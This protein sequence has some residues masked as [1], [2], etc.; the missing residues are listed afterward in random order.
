M[1]I[2]LGAWL[3]GGVFA[4]ML[5]FCRIG[6]AFM[7]L[8]GFGEVFT[9]ARFRL[10]L[11]LG[12]CFALVPVLGPRLPSMP[13][14][15]GASFLLI[16]T[17]IMTGLFMGL[18]A[19]V[20]VLILENAGM[21]ISHQMGLA[22]AHMFNPQIETQGSF[23]GMLLSL[24]GLVLLFETD[25]HHM[26]ILGV[27]ESYD[28]FVPGASLMVDDMA[29]TFARTVSSAFTIG[30]QIAAPMLIVGLMLY[31][32]LGLLARLMPQFQVFF[33]ALPLQ[34]FMG[35]LVMLLSLDAMMLFWLTCFEDRMTTLFG[36]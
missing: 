32:A 18:F 19:R 26:M 21:V 1:T 2:D 17:E 9:P 30:V 10:L 11:A 35:F 28:T 31:F 27:V 23:A 13:T 20:L 6:S 4:F 22:N 8:P 14:G 3:T 36:L 15:A 24:L 12:L 5:L 7:V 25:L 33:V 29:E 16:A 34:I